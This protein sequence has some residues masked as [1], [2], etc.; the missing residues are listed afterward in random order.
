MTGVSYFL[1]LVF[2]K[3][4]FDAAVYNYVKQVIY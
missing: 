1:W 3:L 2:N 4:E